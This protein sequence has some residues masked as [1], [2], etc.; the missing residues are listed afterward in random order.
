MWVDANSNGVTDSGELKTLKDM[1]IESIGLAENFINGTRKIDQNFIFGTSVY[2]RTNGT[3]G[4]VGDVALTYRPSKLPPVPA[5]TAPP[6][7]AIPPVAPPAA[8]ENSD[9]ATPLET[10]LP[11]VFSSASIATLASFDFAGNAPVGP[12]PLPAFA[13]AAH[14]FGSAIAAFGADTG[15]AEINGIFD[16]P[17]PGG[18]SLVPNA[19]LSSAVQGS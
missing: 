18:F 5:I 4:S 15:I 2:K 6:A 10:L 19:S 14:L 1:G 13:A 9:P 12:A 8:P 16:P 17:N 11:D 3:Q 7:D